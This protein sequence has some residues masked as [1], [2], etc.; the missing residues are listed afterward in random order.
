MNPNISYTP[1]AHVIEALPA[2]FRPSTP[3]ELKSETDK[4]VVIAKALGRELDLFGSVTAFKRA[5]ILSREE[6]KSQN[7]KNEI[8]YGLLLAYYLGNKYDSVCE[9]FEKSNLQVSKDTF[10][11]YKE[12]LII[13]YDSYRRQGAEK[14]Q[15]ALY[16]LLKGYS[17][18]LAEKITLYE[19]FVQGNLDR[20]PKDI[21]TA[22]HLHR[23][24][25]AK[26]GWLN[27][28]L[29]GAG[30]YYVGQK[31]TALTSF[32]LNALF[33]AA[34]YEFFHHGQPAAGFI[35]L[36]FEAGWYIGGIRGAKDAAVHYNSNIY[37]YL[38][39]ERM[40]QDRL[41]PLLMFDYGF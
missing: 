27:A 14:R 28:M 41:F 19:A 20:L 30:Y 15:Q 38:A 5:R 22:Y 4:E 36:G 23:K 32:L 6:N 21:Q 16:P 34:S 8:E 25:P 24:S 18:P 37:N 33:I 31:E 1:E 35:T 39:K 10:T 9:S 17:E 26:A 3:L 13:L 11:P 7:L 29:P 12:L 40:M 2:P